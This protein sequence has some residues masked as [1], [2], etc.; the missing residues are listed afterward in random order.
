MSCLS[1]PGQTRLF[2]MAAIGRS[3]TVARPRYWASRTGVARFVEWMRQRGGPESR[4]AR[5]W[6]SIYSKRRPADRLSSCVAAQPGPAGRLPAP[7]RRRGRLAQPLDGDRGA[8]RIDPHQRRR[9][10]RPVSAGPTDQCPRSGAR[11]K[12]GKVLGNFPLAPIAHRVTWQSAK[13]PRL[14]VAAFGPRPNPK[15][16]TAECPSHTRYHDRKSGNE[17][18]RE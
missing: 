17:T 13:R 3:G 10:R 12:N 18:E 2:M 14:A 11:G 5:C 8:C 16:L 9:P 4:Q 7:G 6:A 15:Q 1:C